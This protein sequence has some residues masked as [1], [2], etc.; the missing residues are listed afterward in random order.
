VTSDTIK[1]QWRLPEPALPADPMLTPQFCR[2]W[3]ASACRNMM[4]MNGT[5]HNSRDRYAGTLRDAAP[6][7]SSAAATLEYFQM[8]LEDVEARMIPR[9]GD[10]CD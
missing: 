9:V 8:R 4:P 1:F 10:Q 7:L 6:K 2:C 3:C 5:G